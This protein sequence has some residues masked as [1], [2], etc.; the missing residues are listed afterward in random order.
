MMR[1]ICVLMI[2]AGGA[3]ANPIETMQGTAM[4]A[5]DRMPNVVVVSKVSGICGANDRVNTQAAYCTSDNTIYLA[6]KAADL[7]ETL[8]L[9]GHLYGHAVQVQHGVADVVLREIRSRPADEQILRT[10]VEQQVECIA[11]FLV[12]EAGLDAWD[13][14][15]LYD[16]A[17]F[18]GIH[19]GRS[20]LT[21]GPS[22]TVPLNSR[23]DWFSTGQS[24][25]LAACAP[26][27]FS[28]DLLIAAYRDR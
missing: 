11:G 3:Q 19:W 2:L 6:E 26:G 22:V 10:W 7:P 13:L 21:R 14:Q 24:D 18:N 4:D 1:W 5:F 17:R 9:L 20:P 16:D 15:T 25:G 27:E 28:S 23:A 12:A 8:H